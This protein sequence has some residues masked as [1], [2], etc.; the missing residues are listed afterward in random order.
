MHLNKQYQCIYI[1]DIL[2]KYY[3]WPHI[4]QILFKNIVV[5]IIGAIISYQKFEAELS[6]Y[7]EVVYMWYDMPV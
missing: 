1:N 7:F 4:F 3:F 2:V 6:T 5:I